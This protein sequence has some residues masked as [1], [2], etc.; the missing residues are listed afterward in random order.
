M[1]ISKLDLVF[2]G[3]LKVK[4]GVFLANENSIPEFKSH[5]KIE[6]DCAYLSLFFVFNFL[7]QWHL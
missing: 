7:R 1:D 2:L 3:T 5:T 4:V 6:T